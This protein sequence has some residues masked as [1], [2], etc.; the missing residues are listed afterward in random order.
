M[1]WPSPSKNTL[2]LTTI[3]G[4]NEM[5]GDSI[6]GTGT[7]SQLPD[8]VRAAADISTRFSSSSIPQ[9][10]GK[11]QV[12]GVGGAA[13]MRRQIFRRQDHFAKLAKPSNPNRCTSCR[14]DIL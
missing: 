7:S 3:S 2:W 10:N 9:A 8:V 14:S 4:M 1:P 6:D 13:A 11:Y 5:C 12:V